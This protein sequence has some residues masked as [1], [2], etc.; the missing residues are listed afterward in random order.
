MS[1]VKLCAATAELLASST[2]SCKEIE[3][4]LNCHQLVLKVGKAKTEAYGSQPEC[5]SLS[6]AFGSDTTVLCLV[7]VGLCYQRGHIHEF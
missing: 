6:L 2:A 3:E 7:C 5:P 4:L 1:T